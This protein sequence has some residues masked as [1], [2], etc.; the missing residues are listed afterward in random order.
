MNV[1][2]YSVYSDFLLKIN[3]K[4]VYEPIYL[5]T[6]YLKSI[7]IFFKQTEIHFSGLIFASMVWAKDERKIQYYYV[8]EEKQ[9]FFLALHFVPNLQS[10]VYILFQ[11]Y[12]N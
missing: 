1:V 5:I 10:A 2:I 11:R 12:V 4:I 6:L 7:L 8:L 9:F 3:V